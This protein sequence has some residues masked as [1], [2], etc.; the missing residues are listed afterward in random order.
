MVPLV[1]ISER[2]IDLIEPYQDATLLEIGVA[3]GELA[4]RFCVSPH[5][6]K[7]YG[8]D[9]WTEYTTPPDL[10]F[11]QG[12]IRDPDAENSPSFFEILFQEA[13]E[14]LSKFN[15][16]S[17][18]IRDYSHKQVNCFEDNFFDIIYI[19]GNHQYEYVLKDIKGWYS[20][21]KPNGMMLINEFDK[22]PSFDQNNLFQSY[23]VKPAVIDFCKEFDLKYLHYPNHAIIYKHN[24]AIRALKNTH[25]N[26]SAIV[27]DSRRSHLET[28]RFLVTPSSRATLIFSDSSLLKQ[29][30]ERFLVGYVIIDELLDP[31][32]L[33][34]LSNRYGNLKFIVNAKQIAQHELEN[35]PNANVFFTHFVK[36]T[37]IIQNVTFSRHLDQFITNYE[38]GIDRAWQLASYLG[39]S[40]IYSSGMNSYRQYV[41]TGK[42]VRN[43]MKQLY[44]ECRKTIK[45]YNITQDSEI[46]CFPLAE[47]KKEGSVLVRRSL[48]IYRLI[49]LIENKIK[50]IIYY[51]YPDVP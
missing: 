32:H 16:K 6:K 31:T 35:Y 41:H 21:L 51:N 42:K 34:A 11:V 14:R 40:T 48:F 23:T 1:N 17:K 24:P 33:M 29:L 36:P 27:I 7:Y 37:R 39:C 44:Q 49:K 28:V 25:L 13:R 3:D 38:I 15:S 43:L 45:C 30:E 8:I 10:N 4:E 19:N 9:P 50:G 26:H 20:K 12:Y 5:I 46:D 22:E 18:L 2:I 47:L